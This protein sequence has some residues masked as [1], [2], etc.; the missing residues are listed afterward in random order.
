MVLV[1]ALEFPVFD[2]PD[3]T[4]FEMEFT[5]CQASSVLWE[6]FI[7]RRNLAETVSTRTHCAYFRITGF[8][9]SNPCVG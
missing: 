8:Q 5:E 7:A 9:F 4:D 1:K 2:R 3:S 6:K